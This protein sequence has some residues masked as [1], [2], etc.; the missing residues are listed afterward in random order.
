MKA[1]ERSTLEG[2]RH[3]AT[4]ESANPWAGANGQTNPRSGWRLS[5]PQIPL[6]IFDSVR[7]EQRDQLFLEGHALVMPLLIGDVSLN[8]LDLR[9][10]HAKRA[11]STLP[12]EPAQGAK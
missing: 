3:K 2:C 8:L 4:G 6:V 5:V 1:N 11:V 10:T 7:I 9:L 12:C